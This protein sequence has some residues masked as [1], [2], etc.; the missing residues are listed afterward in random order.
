ML[1]KKMINSVYFALFP[2]KM[3]NSVYFVWGNFLKVET[4]LWCLKGVAIVEP[5]VGNWGMLE[6][7]EISRNP[8]DTQHRINLLALN[9]GE[10]KP[11]S[12]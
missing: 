7:L 11:D 12:H 5:I 3:I 8:A 9:T 6:S 1:P 10:Q 4:G 2:K